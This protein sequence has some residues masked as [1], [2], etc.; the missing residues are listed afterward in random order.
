MK[1]NL[2][3]PVRICMQRGRILGTP[4]VIKQS[5]ATQA[6]T[7]TSKLRNLLQSLDGNLLAP[8]DSI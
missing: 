4:I 3:V 5:N 6:L 8:R 1:N 2:V 7:M